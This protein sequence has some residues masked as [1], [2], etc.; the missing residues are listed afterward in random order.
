MD[1]IAEIKGAISK[2]KNDATWIKLQ[3]RWD[4][5]FNLYRLEPYNAGKNYFSYT[6]NA[7]RNLANKAIEMLSE[8]KLVIRVPEDTLQK[9]E[10]ETANNIERFMYG[11]IGMNDDRF[12]AIDLPSLHSQMSWLAIIRGSIA[13][14]PYIQK[15]KDGTFPGLRV[16]D[17]YNVSYGMGARGTE[18]TAFERMASKEEIKS[19]YNIDISKAEGLVIDFWDKENNAVIVESEWG[20]APEAHGLDHCPVFI[21]KVGGMPPVHQLRYSFT[22]MHRGESIFAADRGIFPLL[23]KSLSD[24]LTIVRR[25]VK[26][27]LGYWSAGGHKNFQEDI[28]QVEHGIA[29][30]MDLDD[31]VKPLIEPTMPADAKDLINFI[32]AEVQ[33]GGI[34]HVAQG[35]LGFRLSGFAINQLQ[36]S[37]ASIITPFVQCLERAYLVSMHSL[38]K[39]YI[40]G[41]WKPI[42]VRGRTSKNQPF[43]V[44]QPIKISPSDLKDWRPE[45]TI[46]PIFPKDDAQRYQLARLATEGET[47]LLSVKTAQEQIIGVEDTLLEGEKIA[48][49]WADNLPVLRLWKAFK[50]AL[51]EGDVDTAFNIVSELQRLMQG[52]VRG[53]PNQQ[54]AMS[55]LGAMST[56][57][58]G[59]GLPA[60]G[61]TG[62][63]PEVSPPELGGGFPAGA[64]RVGGSV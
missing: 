64:E 50:A 53:S 34:S 17:M 45:I 16:W 60:S 21:I 59:V 51:A 9:E 12:N 13:V 47:P 63:S 55:A 19:E 14:R 61:E 31:I 23:N 58:A 22:N 57:L 3:K 25:G 15:E 5:D 30:P 1:T 46:T 32:M 10:V 56:Q 33:R 8:S 18:W 11:V 52:Q 39:Q 62:L 43:G 27:P 42:E 49:Q 26:P 2:F 54:G 41:G 7:P 24:F 44:P 35:E 48:A 37:L 29:V 4:D 28:W 20:K 38:L 6:S 36:A 40:K